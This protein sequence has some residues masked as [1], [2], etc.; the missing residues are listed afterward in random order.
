MEECNFSIVIVHCIRITVNTAIND[1][2]N[3]YWWLVIVAL[4]A[5]ETIRLEKN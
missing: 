2:V 5:F 3:C 4:A 1:S